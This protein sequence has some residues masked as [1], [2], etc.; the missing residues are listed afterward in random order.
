[1]DEWSSLNAE[2]N[3]TLNHVQ[4]QV[5]IYQLDLISLPPT[6]FDLI[7]AN[8]QLNVIV[9]LLDEMKRRLSPTGTFILSGLL[10]PDREDIVQHLTKHGFAVQEEIRENEWIAVAAGRVRA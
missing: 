3:V 10:I 5:T 8:I 4:D 6:T 7:V 1:V 9:P 2:E